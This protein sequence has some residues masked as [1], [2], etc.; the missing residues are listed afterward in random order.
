MKWVNGCVGVV[1]AEVEEG[2]RKEVRRNRGGLGVLEGVL[3][4]EVQRL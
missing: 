2:G 1:M 3:V 4:R